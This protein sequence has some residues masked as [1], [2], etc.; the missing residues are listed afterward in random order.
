M[1]KGSIGIVKGG[2][3]AG[4]Y[5]VLTFVAAALGLSRVAIRYYETCGRKLTLDMA[6]KVAGV[7]GVS[8]DE[9]FT[10]TEGV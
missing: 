4:A 6:A 2:V 10:K 1:K 8:V 3:I 5:V 9:L 7:Y